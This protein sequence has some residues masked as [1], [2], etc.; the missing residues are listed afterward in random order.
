MRNKFYVNSMEIS[1]LIPKFK[2]RD[3]LTKFLDL[4]GL[5]YDSLTVNREDSMEL[6]EEFLW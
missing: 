4:K 1:L 2:K 3:L 6:F 5:K